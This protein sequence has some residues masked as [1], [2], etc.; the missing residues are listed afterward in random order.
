[1]AEID[2]NGQN[3]G[4][5]VDAFNQKAVHV[6]GIKEAVDNAN[7]EIKANWEGDPE[8]LVGRD[9]DLKTISDNMAII[10]K[11]LES[12]AGFLNDK[13]TDFSQIHYN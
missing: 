3:L 11:N 12:I 7:A 4:E 9:K 5:I 13:N 10:Q 1:M 2:Y 6:G 8:E